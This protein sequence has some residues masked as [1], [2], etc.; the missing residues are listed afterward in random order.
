MFDYSRSNPVV[1]AWL[2]AQLTNRLSHRLVDVTVFCLH[3]TSVKF[4]VWS[5]HWTNEQQNSQSWSYTGHVA[6]VEKH[7]TAKYQICISNFFWHKSHFPKFSVVFNVG[8]VAI[9][10]IIVQNLIIYF[11]N[12]DS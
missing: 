3:F 2:P 7:R 1:D 5:S 12:A 6:L 10:G 9:T 8:D 11:C 4:I